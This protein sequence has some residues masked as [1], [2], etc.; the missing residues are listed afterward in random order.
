MAGT[1]R[2]CSRYLTGHG[3]GVKAKKAKKKKNKEEKRR[4]HRAEIG[5]CKTTSSREGP[6]CESTYERQ[7][8][9]LPSMVFYSTSAGGAVAITIDGLKIVKSIA[10]GR[11]MN[12]SVLPLFITKDAVLRNTS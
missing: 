1:P 9:T 10:H 11:P 2:P 5:G 6:S 3:G 8:S 7:T 4:I 12:R